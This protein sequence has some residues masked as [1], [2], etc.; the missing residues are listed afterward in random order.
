MA[1]K[2]QTFR[3]KMRQRRKELTKGLLIQAGKELSSISAYTV[4]EVTG[5]PHG[6]KPKCTL[7]KGW[8]E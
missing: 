5:Q 3:A 6:K 4:R 8:F 2:K 1:L 7:K